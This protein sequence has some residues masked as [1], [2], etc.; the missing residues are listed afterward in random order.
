VKIE[1][2]P[3]LALGGGSNSALEHFR[4]TL[5]SG[6][7]PTPVQGKFEDLPGHY[8]SQLGGLVAPRAVP[9]PPPPQSLSRADGA[10]GG[11]DG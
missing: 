7:D 11:V 5:T 9:L 3:P 1:G 8:F 2:V 4:F 10:A 6:S